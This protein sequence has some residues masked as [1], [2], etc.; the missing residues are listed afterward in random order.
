MT[1]KLKINVAVLWWPLNSV[2][3]ENMD[4]Q[5]IVEVVN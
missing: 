2:C 1:Y 5:I 3:L 4:R